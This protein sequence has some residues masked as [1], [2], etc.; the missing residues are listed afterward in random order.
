MK[1]C[2]SH[3]AKFSAIPW[4]S[5]RLKAF[6]FVLLA[7]L[8]RS[9]HAQSNPESQEHVWDFSLWGAAT[10]GEEN[11]NSF[12]EAQILIAGIFVGHALTSEV[13][14]GW[15]RGHLEYA[16]DFVPVFVQYAPRK[17]KGST[18]DPV[19]LRWNSSMHGGRVSPFLELG[20]GGIHTSGDF[21]QGNT[22]TFNFVARGGGGVLIATRPAQALEIACRWWHISNANLGTQNPEFNGVQL[23]V[24]WHWFK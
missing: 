15:H 1:V 19:I 24:G 7:S 14:S 16:A 5:L 21:P 20:G 17:I 11:T 6:I 9:T 18:F 23:S 4:R 12:S 13:G 2:F 10:T 8:A 22:S 3:V